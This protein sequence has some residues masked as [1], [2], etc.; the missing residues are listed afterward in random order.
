MWE[1][2]LEV[3]GCLEKEAEILVD[4]S[5]PVLGSRGFYWITLVPKKGQKMCLV[6]FLKVKLKVLNQSRILDGSSQVLLSG[7]AV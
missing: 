6:C 4:F 5:E 3:F 1:F 7:T 2:Q